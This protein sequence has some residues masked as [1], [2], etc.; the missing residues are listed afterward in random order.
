MGGIAL[1]MVL[2]LDTTAAKLTD[3]CCGADTS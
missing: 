2:L 3:R 1:M